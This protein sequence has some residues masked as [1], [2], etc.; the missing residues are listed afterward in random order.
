MP[1]CLKTAR[2]CLIVVL[3]LDM[4]P[5]HNKKPI[6][7]NDCHNNKNWPVIVT[8]LEK[9][10]I[11]IPFNNDCPTNH[12]A[13]KIQV[14]T[15]TTQVIR[16][17][18]RSMQVHQKVLQTRLPEDATATSGQRTEC[19]ASAR[20]M[21]AGQLRLPAAPCAAPACPSAGWSVWRPAATFP[22]APAPLHFA[23]WLSTAPCVHHTGEDE[24][25]RSVVGSIFYTHSFPF[26]SCTTL[27]R[28][29]RHLKTDLPTTKRQHLPSYL[30]PPTPLLPHT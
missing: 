15:T 10:P 21:E 22:P 20:P 5:K 28:A 4:C 12:P 7:K 17:R 9:I 16:N 19:S 6:T 18:L 25:C 30:P 8:K 3:I 26:Q 27:S 11:A 24:S 1:T 29:A 2:V 14:S 13:I 23:K